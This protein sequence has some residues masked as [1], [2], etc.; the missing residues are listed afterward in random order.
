MYSPFSNS[1]L[2]SP[3]EGDNTLYTHLT[4]ETILYILTLRG[5]HNSYEYESK[6]NEYLDPHEDKPV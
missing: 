5:T 1:T 4:R 2:Y 3:Y 6:S